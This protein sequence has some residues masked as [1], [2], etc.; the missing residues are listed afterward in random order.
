MKIFSETLLD[1][2]AAQAAASPRKRA[3]HSIHAAAADPVQ[4]FF[5]A[6]DRDTYFRPHRH[7]SKSELALVLRGRF[8]ILTFDDAGRVSGRYSVGGNTGGFGYETPSGTWH[9]LIAC[10]DG[11]TFLE[12]KEGPYDPA[13]AA[14]FA[15]WAPPEGDPSVPRFLE[16]LRRAEPGAGAYQAG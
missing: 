12:I 7:S 8:D 11:A 6:A 5:V 2:L 9:T 13:T 16:W 14:E 4:R 10:T 3:H 1:T 15:S